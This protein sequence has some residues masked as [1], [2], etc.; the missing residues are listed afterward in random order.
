[1]PKLKLNENHEAKLK[2]LLHK[3]NSNEIKI[4]S[5]ATK[6]FIKLLKGDSGGELLYYFVQNSAKCSELLGAWNLRRGK[7]GMFYILKLISVILGHPDGVYEPNDMGRKR[8]SRVLDKFARSLIEHQLEDVHKE[9]KSKEAKRQKAALLLLASIVRRGT[10][11]AS[12]VEKK[13]DFKLEGFRKMGEYKRKPNER[14]IKLSLRKSFVGFAMSFLEVGTPGL[15]RSVIRQRDM[16]SSVMCGLGNDDE[17][18]VIYVLSTLQNRILVEGSLVPP[19][20]RSVLFGSFTL[21]QLAHISGRE[22]GGPSSEL[23]YR[24]LVMVCTDPSNGLMEDSKRHLK[25]NLKRQMDLMKKLKATEIV[26][27]RDLLLAVVCGR[28]SLGAAYMEEF[29]YNL[30]DY[31]SPNWSEF[32]YTTSFDYLLLNFRSSPITLYLCDD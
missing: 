29:P 21:E 4:W 30:E 19:G 14:R 31:A 22:N 15:L 28:P 20:L 7:L 23:A 24:V 12:E 9:L 17:E 6:E 1:M 3:I 2:E 27:H 18:T 11:L 32:I 25:G 16:Y 8:V 5:D 10:V 13:F 26:Y